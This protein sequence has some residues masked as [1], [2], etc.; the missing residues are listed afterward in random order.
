MLNQFL[1]ICFVTLLITHLYACDQAD[2]QRSHHRSEDT[3]DQT[4]KGGDDKK[5]EADET[6]EPTVETPG[7]PT[8]FSVTRGWEDLTPASDLGRSGASFVTVGNQLFVWGGLQ[9]GVASGSGYRYDF[10]TKA[11][12][13]MSSGL[14][15]KTN[16]I[17]LNVGGKVFLWGGYKQSPTIAVNF[18]AGGKLYDPATDSWA[19]ISDTNAP[20][21]TGTIGIANDKN[22]YVISCNYI[23]TYELASNTW[24]QIQAMTGGDCYTNRSVHWFDEKT[25]AIVSF[26]HRPQISFW[27]IDEHIVKRDDRNTKVSADLWQNDRQSFAVAV[28]GGKVLFHGGSGLAGSTVTDYNDAVIYDYAANTWTKLT[29]DNTVSKRSQHTAFYH[30]SRFVMVGGYVMTSPSTAASVR[31]MVVYDPTKNTWDVLPFNQ[32]KNPC[33]AEA[34]ETHWD[35]QRFIFIMESFTTTHPPTCSFGG[36]YTPSAN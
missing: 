19:N 3:G 26:P 1:S 25:L 11:W 7:A 30:D 12:T 4:G 16:H 28:G 22:V 27:K 29:P 8:V 32:T 5:D 17:G 15:S 31:D 10:V 21:F 23:Y 24:K 18:R 36:V 14:I 13:I 2:N 35:G 9:N 34:G 33:T 20:E 6:P